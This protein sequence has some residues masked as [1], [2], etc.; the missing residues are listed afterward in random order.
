MT[1]NVLS[2]TLS[3]HTSTAY[4][5]DDDDYDDDSNAGEWRKET[6]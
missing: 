5:I 1:Y 3:L 6:C 4:C 2:G